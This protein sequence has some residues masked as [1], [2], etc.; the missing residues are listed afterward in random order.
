MTVHLDPYPCSN[1]W[2]AIRVE[3]RTDEILCLHAPDGTRIAVLTL[4]LS[5]V[6]E[7]T[8]VSICLGGEEATA[9]VSLLPKEV[10]S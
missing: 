8:P 3:G 2:P 9:Q 6:I 10:L 1:L 4:A 7:E 5:S